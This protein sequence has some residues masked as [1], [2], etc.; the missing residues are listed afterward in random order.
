MAIIANVHLIDAANIFNKKAT[1][2][3]WLKERCIT[4]FSV[5]LIRPCRMYRLMYTHRV[6]LSN[7]QTISTRQNYLRTLEFSEANIFQVVQSGSTCSLFH[8]PDAK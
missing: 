5:W 7:I 2:L 3:V 8:S 4:V 1:W 6:R